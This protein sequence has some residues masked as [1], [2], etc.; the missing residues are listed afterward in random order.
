MCDIFSLVLQSAGGALADGGD[1][2]GINIMIAG[3]ACQVAS[4][5]IFMLLC[6][7]YARCV[8][9]EGRGQISRSRESI[10]KMGSSV[11][12][13]HFFIGCKLFETLTG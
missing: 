8:K 6:A 12:K 4:L 3:L 13:V 5:A 7:D 2:T 1:Q 9:M 10:N 11:G